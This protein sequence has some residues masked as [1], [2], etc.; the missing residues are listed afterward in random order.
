MTKELPD[1]FT[2]QA[3]EIDGNPFELSI[4]D[5]TLDIQETIQQ[6]TKREIAHIEE[7]IKHAILNGYNG[8][9]VLRPPVHDMDS[10]GIVKINPWNEEPEPKRGYQ[11]TRYTWDWFDNE[12]LRRAIRED[13]LD[14]LMPKLQGGDDD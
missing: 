3:I 13:R 14:E 9:D 8:I 10:F 5:I 2:G 7:E 6:H 11:V 1:K 4:E 12:E